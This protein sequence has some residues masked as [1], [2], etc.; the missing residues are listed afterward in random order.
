M[1]RALGGSRVESIPSLLRQ[2]ATPRRR[3]RPAPR[4]RD[5]HPVLQ[6]SA[7]VAGGSVQAHSR[8]TCLYYRRKPTAEVEKGRQLGLSLPEAGSI[9]RGTEQQEAE[10]TRTPGAPS[11][12]ASA[13][14]RALHAR[15]DPPL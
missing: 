6:R 10:S 4:R 7:G 14:M 1:G 15:G 9:I 11:R 13:R 8:V 5:G 3:P 2:A 12:G